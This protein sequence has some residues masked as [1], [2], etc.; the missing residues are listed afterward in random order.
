[1]WLRIRELV[2]F[3]APIALLLGGALWI[4][5]LLVQPAPPASLVIATGGTSGAYYAYGRRYAEILA[6]SGV[7]LEVRSTAGSVENA[8]LLADPGSGVSVARAK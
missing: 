1:M 7:Q 8:R 2:Y 4:A 6:K 5:S 3:I